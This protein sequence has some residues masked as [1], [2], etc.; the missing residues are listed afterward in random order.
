MSKQRTFVFV[1]RLTSSLRGKV[2]WP[3]HAKCLLLSEWHSIPLS[4]CVHI[5]S[6]DMIPVWKKLG[7]DFCWHKLA[8]YMAMEFF[9]GCSNKSP[10]MEINGNNL[11]DSD[12][13]LGYKYMA[14]GS[15]KHSCHNRNLLTK[16]KSPTNVKLLQ[17]NL[18][19]HSLINW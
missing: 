1:F 5:S 2:P 13:A 10:N 12:P 16:S 7:E 9:R 4:I 18:Q 17:R 14:A 3:G 6:S 11:S 19:Y 8:S 15:N